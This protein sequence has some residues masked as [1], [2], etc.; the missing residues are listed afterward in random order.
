VFAELAK[1]RLDH[2][3]ALRAMQTFVARPPPGSLLA[4]LRGDE[5]RIHLERIP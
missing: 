1:K 3:A 2:R 5:G 4:T